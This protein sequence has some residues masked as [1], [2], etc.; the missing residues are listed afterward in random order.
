VIRAASN[1]DVEAIVAVFEPS[2]AT[3][4]F[5][6]ALHTHEEHLDFFGRAVQEREAFVWDDGGV[7][8]FAVLDGD[9]L[10]HLYVA[11]AAFGRGIGSALLDEAKR[12]RP[13][14]FGFWVFQDNA[15]ARRFYEAHGR[16]GVL[17]T[18]GADNEE[19]MPDVL[20]EWRPCS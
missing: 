3:L 1:E 2:F 16:V 6:P 15:R 20:Y 13:G 5:L 4:D 11:P 9:M 18:D 8:G 14:G 19:R 7:E 17:F 12:R 10:G